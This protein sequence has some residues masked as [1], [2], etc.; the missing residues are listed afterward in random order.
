[1]DW[2]AIIVAVLG[3]VAAIWQARGKAQY[4]AAAKAVI[5]G[6]E[7]Y[8]QNGGNLK[9]TIKTV[10]ASDGAQDFLHGLVKQVTK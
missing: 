3:A 7:A 9:A 8:S 10:A 5:K 4:A 1:M 6:V 2:T